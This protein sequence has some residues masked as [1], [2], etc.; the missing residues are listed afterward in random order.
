[1]R[2]P[3][4]G[5]LVL[6]DRRDDLRGNV[7]RHAQQPLHVGQGDLGKELPHPAPGRAFPKSEKPAGRAVEPQGVQIRQRPVARRQ[8][9]DGRPEHGTVGRPPA[10][11]LDAHG[12]RQSVEQPHALRHGGKHGSAAKASQSVISEVVL[13]FQG[14]RE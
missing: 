8:R 2:E 14:G 1:M 10:P 12:I 13:D 9:R 6:D 3:P 4:L 5:N 11:R 7:P